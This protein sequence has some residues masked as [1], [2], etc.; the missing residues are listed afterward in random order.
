MATKI[1]AK[2]RKPA[3]S[4]NIVILGELEPLWVAIYQN[5]FHTSDVR[6]EDPRK[7][8]CELMNEV[9]HGISA[10]AVSRPV[11]KAVAK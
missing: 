2:N 10:R 9:G 8:Y 5:G 6:L 3:S 4:R 11:G 7:R 1:K